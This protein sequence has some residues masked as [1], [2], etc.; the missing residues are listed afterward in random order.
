MGKTYKNFL[1]NIKRKFFTKIDSYMQKEFYHGSCHSYSQCGEDMIIRFAFNAMGICEPSFLD[2]GAHHPFYLS[3][4]AHF[5][6]SGSRGVNI[7]A[8]PQLLQ[9]FRKYRPHDVN[10]NL[11]IMD[12]PSCSTF[13]I[14]DPPYMSTFSKE[15]AED[16]I[17]THGYKIV[18]TID[19][20]AST[21]TDIVDKYFSGGK[22]QFLSLD[23]EGYD[24]KII[25][26][27]DFDRWSPIII[28][29]ET[30]SFAMKGK[31]EKNYSI[32][33]FLKSSGYM[34]Y[35]DTNINT[36]FVREDVWNSR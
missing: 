17:N 25:R 9:D 4:T 18:E 14:M 3:N 27:I 6:M 35:G 8:N 13:Y 30:V 1:R 36:I 29:C 16:L 15:E 7:E 10:L 33:E 32:M 12:E 28:C 23:V 31:S 5:Y 22:P 19:I 20:Q 11:G 2:I 34:V 24:E 21:V 26:S